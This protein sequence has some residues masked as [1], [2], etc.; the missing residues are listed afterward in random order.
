MKCR[1]CQQ[2]NPSHA[3]FC[4]KCGAPLK[5]TDRPEI[6]R[7][8]AEMMWRRFEV[9]MQWCDGKIVGDD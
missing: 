4:L 3:N 9:R 6:R 8:L 2:D 1:G 5:G 7:D